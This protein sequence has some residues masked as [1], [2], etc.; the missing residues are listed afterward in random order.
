MT[1]TLKDHDIFIRQRHQ[2]A[3]DL[4]SRRHISGIGRHLLQLHERKNPN[5]PHGLYVD[6]HEHH[7]ST[8]RLPTTD[9]VFTCASTWLLRDVTDR[10][11]QSTVSVI[12]SSSA[13]RLTPYIRGNIT[14]MTSPHTVRCPITTCDRT[15]AEVSLTTAQ[16]LNLTLCVIKQSRLP[17]FILQP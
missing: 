5:N 17:A 7:S 6:C 10:H 12:G 9:S 16:L 13:T 14:V 15:A 2:V 3:R 8:V 4:I 11:S 1:R